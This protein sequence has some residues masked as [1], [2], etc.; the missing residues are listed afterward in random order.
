MGWAV[1]ISQSLGATNHKVNTTGKIILARIRGKLFFSTV[2]TSLRNRVCME[3]NVSQ[4][5]NFQWLHLIPIDFPPLLVRLL[6]PG[7]CMS[8]T[9]PPSSLTLGTCRSE[10]SWCC[11]RL[12][13]GRLYS[14]GPLLDFFWRRM[15]CS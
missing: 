2:T 3:E 9:L 12:D 11:L 15:R 8:I 1:T 13:R 7:C 5:P 14:C 6:A 10:I 4:I